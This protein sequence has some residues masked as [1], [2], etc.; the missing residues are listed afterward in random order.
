M[1]LLRAI[2]LGAVQGLTEFL[3]I[4]SSGH[5]ILVPA[6]FRWPDQGLAFDAGLHLGTLAA[7]LVYFW[8]DWWEMTL[9]GLRDVFRGHLVHR[10]PDPRTRLLLLLALATIPAAIAGLLLDSWIEENLREPWIVVVSLVVVA[11]IMLAADRLGTLDRTVAGVSVPDAVIIGIAQACALV[12][13]VSRS[14]A[15]ISAGLTRGLTRNDAARFAFLVGTPTIAGAAMLKI[16]DIT[17]DPDEFRHFLAGTVTSAIVGL[18]AIHLFLRYLR[19]RNLVPFVVY[20]YAL[21]L[22]TV[23]IGGFRAL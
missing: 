8:R 15:T 12:P 9:A 11:T 4:S 14:G 23:L 7:L 2:I 18:A 5:L 3:P 16:G 22:G 20:R 21:A 10:R 1:E 19:T 17:A 6:L 13:G